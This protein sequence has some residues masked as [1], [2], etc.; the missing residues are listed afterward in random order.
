MPVF[1]CYKYLD[2]TYKI[3]DGVWRL[4]PFEWCLRVNKGLNS[5]LK[6]LGSFFSSLVKTN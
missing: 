3:V 4:S 6:I 5:G 2:K 1:Y